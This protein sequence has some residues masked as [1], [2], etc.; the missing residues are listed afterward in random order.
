LLLNHLHREELDREQAAIEENESRGLGLMD[1]WRGVADWY[2][3]QVQQIAR[4]E[5]TDDTANPYIVRLEPLEKRRSNRLARYLGSRR[6]VQLRV[7]DKLLRKDGDRIR[8]FIRA[9]FIICGRLFVPLHAKDN[10]VYMVET[11]ENFNRRPDPSCGDTHRKSFQEIIQWLNPLELNFKQV[12][13]GVVYT[14]G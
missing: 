3:G 12:G 4:I 10:G 2:G 7:S 13:V 11:N 8:D 9:K 5:A 6:V 14:D 1:D